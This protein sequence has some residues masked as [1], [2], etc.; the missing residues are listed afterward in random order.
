[1]AAATLYLILLAG[2]GLVCVAHPV[3]MKCAHREVS[4]ILFSFN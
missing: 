1:M 2:A 3:P 4:Y